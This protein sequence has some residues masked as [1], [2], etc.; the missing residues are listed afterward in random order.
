MKYIIDIDGTICT[1]TYGDYDAAEP[2]PERIAHINNLYD[3]GYEIHYWTA[4][5]SNT[6][7][8]WT[9]LTI[10]QLNA[11]GCK[12]TTAKLGK[13]AYD[14]WVDDKAFNDKEFFKCMS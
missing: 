11:W 1:N 9:K 5:G 8:N 12:Y 13:P 4:R 6:G 14:V 3:K 7:I 2:F 10:H